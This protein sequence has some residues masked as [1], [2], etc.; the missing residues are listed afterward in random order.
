MFN[1]HGE[2][3]YHIKLPSSTAEQVIEWFDFTIVLQ[4]RRNRYEFLS[5]KSQKMRNIAFMKV[6]KIPS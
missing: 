4:I 5:M 6:M 3:Q 2:K 1:G